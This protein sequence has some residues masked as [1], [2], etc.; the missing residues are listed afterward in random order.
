[1]NWGIVERP[2]MTKLRNRSKGGFDSGLSRLRVRHS[3]AELS[4]S[5]Y[6]NMPSTWR[7]KQRRT[8]GL[9]INGTIIHQR[10]VY[11]LLLYFV[12][13]GSLIWDLHWC[14]LSLVCYIECYKVCHFRPPLVVFQLRWLHHYMT[15]M[16]IAGV[17]WTP[18]ASFQVFLCYSTT[19][20]RHIK[21]TYQTSVV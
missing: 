12:P 11:M 17:V 6:L 19:P 8:H 20:G 15:T 9:G 5:T 10:N 16:V 1:M 7:G 18:V 4:R 3:S 21:S 14:Q 13:V 2:K